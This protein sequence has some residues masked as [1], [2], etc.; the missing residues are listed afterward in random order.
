MGVPK[1]FRYIS[2]RYPCIIEHLRE[3]ELPE[4]DNFYLDMN[5]II[6]TCSHTD[7]IES[8]LPE[9]EIFKEIFRYVE[10]LFNT[11][12]PK[13]LF[14]LAVDGVAPRAKINQQRG[15]RFRTARSV[16]VEKKK[17]MKKNQTVPEEL[18][19][20]N[21]ITPGTEFMARLDEQLQYFINYKITTDKKWQKPKIIFSG[22]HV[23]G[24]GEHKVMDYIRYLKAQDDWDPDTSHCLHGMDADLIM[25]GL[26]THQ[27][28][29]SILR[30][31]VTCGSI[32]LKRKSIEVFD[33]LHLSLLR[34]YIDLEFKKL[35]DVLPFPYELERII[36]D[37]IL[38]CFLIGND[39]LPNIPT[40]YIAKNILATLFEKY[41][42]ILPTLGGYINEYG[43]LNLERFEKYLQKMAVW[44][45]E[46]FKEN[47]GLFQV[48]DMDQ[49]NENAGQVVKNE[50]DSER[51][52]INGTELAKI[53]RDAKDHVNKM[54]SKQH[55]LSPDEDGNSDDEEAYRAE[56]DLNKKHYYLTKFEDK[57]SKEEVSQTVEEYVKAI[58]WMLTYYYKGCQSWSWYYPFH[59]T[60]Q[61]SDMHSFSDKVFTF[62]DDEPLQPLQQL[63]SVLPSQSHKLL[64]KAFQHLLISPDSPISSYYPVDFQLDFNGKLN[65]W[66]AIVVIP[67]IDQ[68]KLVDAMAPY[69]KDLTEEE[70]L[71]NG[72]RPLLIYS[73]SAEPSGTFKSPGYFPDIVSNRAMSVSLSRKELI[74][75]EARLMASME[76]RVSKGQLCRL[77]TFRDVKL[78]TRLEYG[79]VYLSNVSYQTLMLHIHKRNI[80]MVMS[81]SDENQP[82]DDLD[83]EVECDTDIDKL[84]EIAVSLIAKEVFVNWPHLSRAL[85]VSVV[86]KTHKFMKNESGELVKKELNALE[87]SIFISQLT[88]IKHKYKSNQGI[89]LG[90]VQ[91]IIQVRKNEGK[92]YE[93]K[94]DGKV[95]LV[96]NWSTTLTPVPY[97][98][99]VQ[100]DGYSYDI[101]NAEMDLNEVFAPGDVC[102]FLGSQYYGAKATVI[103]GNVNGK[104]KVN[105]EVPPEPNFSGLV[106]DGEDSHVKYLS[107]SQM[108]QILLTMG[109]KAIAHF[110]GAVI[111]N[112]PTMGKMN[113]GLNLKFNKFKKQIIG[114]SKK[115]DN[116][117][118]KYSTGVM[119]VLTE[120]RDAFPKLFEHAEM[121]HD[122]KLNLQEVYGEDADE[123]VE[124][125]LEWVNEKK[126]EL[127]WS[128]LKRM[129]GSKLLMPAT[130][131]KME[132]VL[133]QTS[134]RGIEPHFVELV[135]RPH[136]LYIPEQKV[137]LKCIDMST[138]VELL[139]RVVFVVKNHK[140][141]LGSKG[142]IV[143]WSCDEDEHVMT[144]DVLFDDEIKELF[145]SK[146][147]DSN[148]YVVSKYSCLNITNWMKSN[149]VNT[150]KMQT[151]PQ[152]PSRNVNLNVNSPVQEENWRI[153]EVSLRPEMPLDNKKQKD[154]SLRPE[155]PPTLDNRKNRVQINPPLMKNTQENNWRN[156][157][158]LLGNEFA[159]KGACAAAPAPPFDKFI[160]SK[161]YTRKEPWQPDVMSN[162]VN[163]RV[164]IHGF[165]KWR[166]Q[167]PGVNNVT[168]FF[169]SYRNNSGV[170]EHASR[171]FADS[172]QQPKQQE[173]MQK[174]TAD[175]EFQAMWN[176]LQQQKLPESQRPPSFQPPIN[177]VNEQ[178]NALKKV[179]KLSDDDDQSK[180]PASVEQMNLRPAPTLNAQVPCGHRNCIDDFIKMCQC[181]DMAYPV[182]SYVHVNQTKFVYC[183]LHFADGSEFKGPQAQDKSTAV[184]Q[185]ACQALRFLENKQTRLQMKPPLL[186]SPPQQWCQNRIPDTKIEEKPI[187]SNKELSFSEAKFVPF[188]VQKSLARSKQPKVSSNGPK[189]Q[190]LPPPQPDQ[191][192]P[193]KAAFKNVDVVKPVPKSL[194]KQE[195]SIRPA[196]VN[197][198][199]RGR[200]RLAAKF[201]MAS[202]K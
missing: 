77:N 188:Q 179:L 12:Q 22:V 177:I 16:E 172:V 149:P 139:D 28:N 150:G 101:T 105:I 85:V 83:A 20:T 174:K 165:N 26:C 35:K 1:F 104:V 96:Y 185:A 66:E 131:A 132:N 117:Y 140:I 69:Y 122:S 181:L 67:F 38:M 54:F 59:Y 3:H 191:P 147:S 91:V 109:A 110:A 74:I 34:E 31:E 192:K 4:F 146:K 2:A 113:I 193:V 43:T 167:E 73:Y 36:D 198:A 151:E 134:S 160:P 29:F 62:P 173:V 171:M 8:S 168:K 162:F 27:P 53:I 94:S 135:V 65:E 24:E 175:S 156:N 169:S 97:E 184:S 18:F 61:L 58:T 95:N 93:F 75:D 178:T 81:W 129:F 14:M 45:F 70:V 79:R 86:S 6:H 159:K 44:E 197:A 182:F 100:L 11:I 190:P 124:E 157:G 114:Y 82:S 112:S 71:R 102:F 21:C 80:S 64:P 57:L 106:T 153:K 72:E 50:L 7:K 119:N 120:Y 163:A 60:P 155:A 115:V 13:K 30:E 9:E 90:P 41:I 142:T 33:F 48:K 89:V 103:N 116:K 15:R 145:T 56:F 52:N 37:W 133:A 195:V 88:E 68:E 39:F 180:M 137:P 92:K 161:V 164:P 118:W 199:G 99:V 136:D 201:S 196:G 42:E 189:S 128:Q 5:G 76:P 183:M 130:I 200:R 123:K 63:V 176:H 51:W 143:G 46:V 144:Y 138:S 126:K 17:L 40:F 152:Q 187:P 141:P 125:I 202:G 10:L 49:A 111:V 25:L 23:P 78:T 32:R 170:P 186:P 55:E 108:S 194:S 127:N 148:V 158:V 107:A 47:F 19:D 154:V 87:R 84:E 98:L 166:T 121:V